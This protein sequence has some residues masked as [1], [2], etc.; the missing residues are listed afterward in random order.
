MKYYVAIDQGGSKTEA[1]IFTDEGRILAFADDR[2]LRKPG[3]SYYKL[4]GRWIRYAA[5]K[6]LAQVGLTT[7]DLSGASCALNGADWAEDYDRLRRL[8]SAELS[9]PEESVKIVNDCVGAMRGGTD[10]GSQG[11]LC[12]GSGM[13]I[14]VRKADGRELIYGYFVNPL[15]QGGGALGTKA[16]Q[17]ILDAYTGV[18]PA[19]RLSSLIL[20][21]YNEP[22]LVSL[23]KKFTGNQIVFRNY[24][25]SPLLMRAGKEG[26]AVAL[27]I[28]ETAGRRMLCYIE[29]GMEKL[30]FGGEQL[31]LVLTGGVFKGDGEILFQLIERMIRD[32]G[33]NIV[34]VK[35]QFEPVAGAALLIVDELEEAKRKAAADRFAADAVSFSLDWG[36][37]ELPVQQ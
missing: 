32:K 15:D 19:T 31:T 27:D 1:L 9:I 10:Q 22:D 26:D 30:D 11:V 33:L 25:L 35:P 28:L 34:C 29:K 12:A 14:A 21:K 18:G 24:D 23:Y 20:E 13:N 8:V 3:E 5:E 37:R 6:A 2:D 16:W 36:S 4:Q 7:K 17:S